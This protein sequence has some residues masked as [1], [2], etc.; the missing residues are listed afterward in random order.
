M[1]TFSLLWQQS[2]ARIRTRNFLAPW[3]RIRTD[4]KSWIRIRTETNADQQH[5]TVFN[6]NKSKKVQA[7]PTVLITLIP[8]RGA[9]FHITGWSAKVRP[10]WLTPIFNRLLT[11]CVILIQ[12]SLEFEQSS[13][14]LQ[15]LVLQSDKWAEITWQTF[16]QLLFS[17]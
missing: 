9:D 3:I 13:E 11:R 10:S 15:D 16:D 17:T 1:Q 6:C 12:P 7:D 4:V 8:G 5:Y 2:L 14:K